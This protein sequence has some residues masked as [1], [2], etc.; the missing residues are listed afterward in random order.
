MLLSVVIITGCAT[1]S[2]LIDADIEKYGSKIAM[3][4]FDECSSRRAM[5]AQNWQRGW[6]QFATDRANVSQGYLNQ[7]KTYNVYH[8]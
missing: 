3:I 2:E 5:A 1:C 6:S 4:K 7:N 8:Y